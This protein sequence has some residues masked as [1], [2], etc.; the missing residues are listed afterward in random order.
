MISVGWKSWKS[1]KSW[2]NWKK[3]AH[4]SFS[5]GR[6]RQTV[7]YIFFEILNLAF[8]KDFI[9]FSFRYLVVNFTKN[10]SFLLGIPNKRINI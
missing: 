5:F 10:I 1:W 4:K 6:G 7:R 9:V 2:K 8:W 3:F